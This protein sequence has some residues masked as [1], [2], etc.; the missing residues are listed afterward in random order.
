MS[1]A[2]RKGERIELRGFGTFSVREQAA[3]QAR[4]PRTGAIISVVAKR[5][6][7][8]K[9]GKELSQRINSHTFS[10]HKAK[11]SHSRSC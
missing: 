6:L 9:V 1:E 2:L 8:F 11:V 5:A 4:N 7:F 10:D 3:R